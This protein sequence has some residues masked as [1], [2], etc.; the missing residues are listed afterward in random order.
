MCIHLNLNSLYSVPVGR[1][2][3]KKL[4][5]ILVV[6]ILVF[7]GLGAVGIS[8]NK[9]IVNTNEN[10]VATSG[11]IVFR[12]WSIVATYSIPE[13]A[14]GLAYDGAY[15][16]CGIYGANG[17]EVYQIDTDTGSYSLL[18]SGPQEDAFGLTYDGVYLWTTDHP[19]SSSTPAV[20]MQLDMN[21]NLFSQFDLPDHYMSGIAY[22]DGDFWVA[23]YYPDPATIYKVDDTGSILQ[24]FTAP[25]DQPWDL[26]LEND[27]LWMA[28]YWG[29]TLYKIDPSTGNLLESHSSEGVDPAGIVWDG[30]YLWYCDNGIDYTDDYLYKIDLAG[31]GTPEIYV[32]ITSHDYGVVTVGD[33]AT[34]DA[35]VE[36][37]GTADLVIQDVAFTGTGS[38]DLSCPLTFPVTINPD[39]QTQIPLVYEPQ[40]AGELNAIATIESNDPV[41]P[42]VDITLTG[43][44][45]N[46][47]PDIYLPESTHDYGTVRINAYTRWLMEIQNT[48]DEVLTIE[49][50]ISDDGHFIVD[51]QVTFPFDIDVLSSVQIGIWFQPAEDIVYSAT[52]SISSNDPDEDP[53]IVSVHGEGLDM[54]YPIGEIIWQYY[55]TGG[56]DNSVKAITPIPDINGDGFADVIICS[57]DDYI[58]CFNGN[59]HAVGDVL[60]EHEIYAGSVYSQKGLAITEDVDYDGYN[61]VVVG[62]AWGGRL[63]RT[64]SGKTGEEIWTHDTHEYGDGGW[65]YQVDCRY[66]YNNDGII[67][68]LAA[69]GDDG[70]DTGP[71]RIYCLNGLTG[72]SIW[73]CPLGGTGFT[74]IG[75]EDFTGDGQPDAVAG[76]SNDAETIGYAYGINGATGSKTWTFTATGSSVWAL[77]QIDDITSDGIKDVIIGDFYGNIY[78]LDATTGD[79]EYSN[80]VGSYAIITR[81][82]KLNDVNGDG[83]PDIVPAH[84][85]SGVKVIDGSTGDFIWSH[86]VADKPA[87]VSRI[88]DISGDGIN[89]VLV[90]TLYTNNYCYFLD[91]TDGSEL[92]SINLDTPVDAIAAIPDIVGDGSMEMIAGGRNGYVACFSGGLDVI[93]GNPPNE[94][95]ITGETNG[96]KGTEYEYTFNS[97]DPDGD[98]VYYWIE[99]GDGQ[100]EK[101]IGPYA[102]GDDVKVKHTWNEEGT[103]TIK[104]RAKDTNG[105]WGE[106][107]TLEVTMPR[108]K[109][110]NKPFNFNFPLL[111]WLFERFPNAFPIL[112]Y[113]LGL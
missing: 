57:E 37:I 59:A 47:G 51:E 104:A 3:M 67:D 68:V 101:W 58:R 32:P 49:D 2:K 92:E 52:L 23:T 91:G 20:A 69:T 96:K 60:W 40:D 50:I 77:E 46:P 18:F 90:G 76:A 7:G 61:D 79:Q 71:R 62:S 9:T 17:D 13:S 5:P 88:E 44:A 10:D 108:N 63:I 107:E 110:I 31:A 35:T 43:N 53:Y 19:G 78:G 22:D 93:P 65:V 11:E 86:P 102:S 55:I 14:A 82:A 45:V 106:W 100:I 41:N 112:R 48:G 113:L 1:K 80:S 39:D 94:P 16:Y 30:A 66:D 29:D 99:W 87:S 21:G 84:L 64:I 33:S 105:L 85:G 54:N 6:G 25:D 38:D 8:S 26:C 15:L 4:L 42:T 111:S 97:V 27:N 56:S 70:H 12:D 28:D 83:H 72:E 109:S 98:D 75:V 24:Q 34:W 73:E 89:D 81:F 95:T 103:Y 74:V 36:N